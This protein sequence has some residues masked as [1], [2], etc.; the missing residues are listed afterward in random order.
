MKIVITGGPGVGKTTLVREI[1]QEV[2]SGAGFVTDVVFEGRKRV[3][4]DICPFGG[5]FMGGA[6][7]R[8][9]DHN[10]HQENFSR[11]EVRKAKCGPY[12]VLVEDFEK[13][14]LDCLSNSCVRQ[15]KLV[16]MDEVGNMT[17]HTP[18]FVARVQELFR[19][20]ESERRE[21]HLL[22]TIPHRA[23]NE[24]ICKEILDMSGVEVIDLNY[25]NW[26]S[27]KADLVERLKVKPAEKEVKPSKH[28]MMAGMLSK[29]E[30]AINAKDHEEGATRDIYKGVE[31]DKSKAEE[32]Q[33]SVLSIR[34]EDRRY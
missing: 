3:G 4:F 1:L 14:A 12:T 7:A 13:V 8:I 33:K 29:M 26:D 20:W 24:D 32:I 21:A 25:A 6:I 15:A 31:N 28:T 9:F 22:A 11:C 17:R 34:G 5:S 23:R 10:N 30:S 2:G 18:R 27:V 16:V 19:E